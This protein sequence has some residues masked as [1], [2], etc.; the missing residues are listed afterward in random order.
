[1][2]IPC[3]I[4]F[5]IDVRFGLVWL[6]WLARMNV[7]TDAVLSDFIHYLCCFPSHC[8]FWN[9]KFK[10]FDRYWEVDY[11]FYFNYHANVTVKRLKCITKLLFFSQWW[12]CWW[13]LNS[14]ASRLNNKKLYFF[15]SFT[16]SS[17]LFCFSHLFFFLGYLFFSQFIY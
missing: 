5:V 11:R 15:F 9:P 4:M 3:I 16:F 17:L 12:W 10:Q 6:V 8:R 7:C 2:F 13:S 14:L 1:M